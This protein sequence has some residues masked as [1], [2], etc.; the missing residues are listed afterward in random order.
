[1]WDLKPATSDL[2]SCHN[3]SL[4]FYFPREFCL[5]SWFGL[6]P[7]PVSWWGWRRKSFGFPLICNKHEI[8]NQLLLTRII[9]SAIWLLLP[10]LFLFFLEPVMLSKYLL[11]L[12]WQWPHLM[13]TT[14][15]ISEALLFL[16]I[17]WTAPHEKACRCTRSIHEKA[18]WTVS[19]KTVRWHEA[20]YVF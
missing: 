9:Q 7:W 12:M 8:F 18:V 20:T 10:S 19:C 3:P 6:V 5:L 16:L 15:K 17:L 2:M 11:L 13:T 14:T 4:C 1:M